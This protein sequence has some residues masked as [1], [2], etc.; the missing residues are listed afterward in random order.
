MII[1]IKDKENLKQFLKS[2]MIWKNLNYKI[3]I[4][5]KETK[6][7]WEYLHAVGRR[8]WGRIRSRIGAKWPTWRHVPGRS[9]WRQPCRKCG[10]TATRKCTLLGKSPS[11]CLKWWLSVWM[12]RDGPSVEYWPIHWNGSAWRPSAVQLCHYKSNY[13]LNN[14]NETHTFDLKC[15]LEYGRIKMSSKVSIC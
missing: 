2:L 8:N 10:K 12:Y 14:N 11:N 5:W 6:W 13:L 4:W 3:K 1:I 15:Y 7:K 9:T